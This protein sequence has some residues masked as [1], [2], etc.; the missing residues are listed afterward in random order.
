MPPHAI[1]SPK[2][3]R[4]GKRKGSDASKAGLPKKSR[5]AD[6]AEVPSMVPLVSLGLTGAEAEQNAP[7]RSGRPNAVTGGRNAQLEKIG[8]VLQSKPRTQERKGTTS[9]GLN[10]PVNPQAPEPR[11]RGRKNHSKAVPPPYSSLVRDAPD[12][13]AKDIIATGP[14]FTSQQPGGRFGFVAPTEIAHSGTAQPNIQALHNPHVTIGA[15]DAEQCA[16][17]AI[18]EQQARDAIAEQQA[19]DAIAEQRA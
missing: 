9:L 1:A 19:R 3:K 11:R 5:A 7:R 17:D 4:S 16:R 6:I 18:A 12:A 8:S 13:P 15:K 14:S 10:V 2:K